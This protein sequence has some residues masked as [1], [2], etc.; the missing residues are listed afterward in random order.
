LLSRATKDIDLFLKRFFYF[1]VCV[2]NCFCDF[3]DLFVGQFF[4]FK[5]FDDFWSDLF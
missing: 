3:F 4:V 1:V 2:L 5:F